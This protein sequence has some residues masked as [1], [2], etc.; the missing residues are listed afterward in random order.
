MARYAAAVT[1]GFMGGLYA[2]H[3]YRPTKV[4]FVRAPP[5]EGEQHDRIFALWG[6]RYKLCQ[7]VE[8]P[9]VYGS[10]LPSGK[11]FWCWHNT[12][13]GMKRSG[14]ILR[15]NGASYEVPEDLRV[16]IN[17]WRVSH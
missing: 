11:H 13:R 9:A 8:N 4:F 3:L 14:G 12:R 2:M 1:A 16:D 10:K 7:V 15:W 17:W 5:R 6:D